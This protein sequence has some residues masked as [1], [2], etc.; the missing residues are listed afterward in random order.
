MT[1]EDILKYANKKS[2]RCVLAVSSCSFLMVGLP[3]ENKV[4][5][6]AFRSAAFVCALSTCVAMHAEQKTHRLVEHAAL[7]AGMISVE[8]SACLVGFLWEWDMME[9]CVLAMSAVMFNG[10]YMVVNGVGKLATALHILV[11]TLCFHL[12]FLFQDTLRE[13]TW[14]VRSLNITGELKEELEPSESGHVTV[15]LTMMSVFVLLSVQMAMTFLTRALSVVPI[16]EFADIVPAPAS[17]PSASETTGHN[18]ATA[19]TYEASGPG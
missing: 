5:S 11:L 13:N 7:H 9:L 8:A 6:N 15:G 10:I 17:T 18:S 1:M 19:R 2:A 12:P 16:G 14:L 4:C 3:G